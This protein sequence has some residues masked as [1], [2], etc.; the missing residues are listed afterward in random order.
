VTTLVCETHRLRLRHLVAATDAPFILGLLN[1]PS[2]IENI[3]DRGVRTVEDAA[4]YIEEGPRAMYAQH[5][6]GLFRVE[7]K[8][9]SATPIGMCGLL[10]REW[11]GDVDVGFAFLPQYWSKGYAFESAA[12]V[13]AWGR[14]T[15]GLTRVVAITA[16]HNLGSARV[17]E[18]LGLKFARLVQ[19]PEGQESRLFTPEG[20]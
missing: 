6:L 12:A 10:K 11:L 16:P 20:I 15:L 19:S 5:G 9:D 4:R 8:D 18:K 2:F 14:E 17:L 13:I 1:E 3:A 7:L